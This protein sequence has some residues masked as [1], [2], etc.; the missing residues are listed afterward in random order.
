MKYLTIW[1]DDV[2][3]SPS[4]FLSRI[5][6]TNLNTNKQ[7]Q[8]FCNDWLAV[9]QSDGLISRILPIASD[10]ELRSFENLFLAKAT[11]DLTDGHIWFSIIM[12][13]ARSNFSRL[14]R[15]ACCLSLLLSTMLSNAMFFRVDET[16]A[17]GN[18]TF[19]LLTTRTII[20]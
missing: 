1:H 5:T 19:F 8:C 14:Q 6:I 12:R 18:L 20:V 10:V 16:R 7:Q 2:G 3:P 17:A 13:P 9:D 11:Q 15:V 4:W